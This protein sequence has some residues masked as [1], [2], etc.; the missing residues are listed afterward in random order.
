MAAGRRMNM[1]NWKI[2]LRWS[3]GCRGLGRNFFA[4]R[5]WKGT[6][7]TTQMPKLEIEEC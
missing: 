7:R 4:K 6:D 3:D 2:G 1:G 5:E